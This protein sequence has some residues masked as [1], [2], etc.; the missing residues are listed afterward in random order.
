[1][2]DEA[3]QGDQR[4]GGWYIRHCEFGSCCGERRPRGSQKVRLHR[5]MMG[6]T[7]SAFRMKKEYRTWEECLS[8]REVK[9]CDSCN[10]TVSYIQLHS[11]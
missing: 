1:M 2:D 11:P 9:V 5:V 10:S 8:L 7:N 4:V 3:I 6:V